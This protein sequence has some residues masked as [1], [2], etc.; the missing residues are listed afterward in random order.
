MLKSFSL[1]PFHNCLPFWCGK[2]PFDIII[3]NF[4]RIATV[5]RM[6]FLCTEIL[7]IT[8]DHRSQAGPTSD[9][10]WEIWFCY[11]STTN[12]NNIIYYSNFNSWVL[13]GLVLL[14]SLWEVYLKALSANTKYSL[15]FKPNL[16]HINWSW[17]N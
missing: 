17:A 5:Q 7:Y 9:V 14:E 10:L 15:I 13:K 11:Y 8:F 16:A 12:F 6:S 2:T 1:Q 4:L 3:E